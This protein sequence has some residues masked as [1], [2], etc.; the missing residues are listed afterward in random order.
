MLKEEGGNQVNQKLR[1]KKTTDPG[2]NSMEA[3]NALVKSY[4]VTTDEEALSGMDQREM[5]RGVGDSSQCL[6]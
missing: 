1:E 4:V 2:L 3:T 5:R 6:G